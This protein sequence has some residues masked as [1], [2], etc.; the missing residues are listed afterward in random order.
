MDACSCCIA[1]HKHVT[2]E[3]GATI[4]V[5]G[6]AAGA[7]AAAL[8]CAVTVKGLRP[9]ST[10][11]E[12]S[13]ELRLGEPS[14][15]TTV[16]QVEEEE[17]EKPSPWRIHPPKVL[18]A[19]LWRTKSLAEG[20]LQE[21]MD[22]EDAPLRAGRASA[23][24]DDFWSG[25]ARR[26]TML[27]ACPR[28]RPRLSSDGL[29]RFEVNGRPLTQRGFLQTFAEPRL[30]P[31]GNVGQTRAAWVPAVAAAQAFRM[32]VMQ[33]CGDG[34][35]GVYWKGPGFTVSSLDNEFVAL[36]CGTAAPLSS[37]GDGTKF[38]VNPATV[39]DSSQDSEH[40][41]LTHGFI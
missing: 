21:I 6:A 24:P 17:E 20:S 10:G 5:A 35:G 32:A 8:M 39:R 40:R 27:A 12:S 18:G 26:A 9:M 16:R 13:S 7:A 15:S 4:F 1:S 34:S 3:C 41:F 28:I 2:T 38:T 37:R 25:S 14:G 11:L 31:G 33:S 36:C 22:C 23:D 19:E 30:E 29:V